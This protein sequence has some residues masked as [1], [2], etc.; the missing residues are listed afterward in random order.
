MRT[1]KGSH[2]PWTSPDQKGLWAAPEPPDCCGFLW[3]GQTH[4]LCTDPEPG[5]AQ[6][7]QG[8]SKMPGPTGT[9]PKNPGHPTLP[10]P[11]QNQK[12]SVRQGQVL[13]A[14]H[15]H[16]PHQKSSLGTF[17]CK[18]NGCV[19]GSW[20]QLFTEPKIIPCLAPRTILNVFYITLVEALTRHK[21][22]LLAGH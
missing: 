19:D 15:L 14:S 8:S 18:S 1:R 20:S 2:R 4:P 9:L 3:Q 6:G 12:P 11:E 13:A 17:F 21:T 5:A 10:N 22:Q 16:K 7:S